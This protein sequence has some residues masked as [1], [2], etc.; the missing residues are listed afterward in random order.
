MK[1]SKFLIAAIAAAGM[2]GSASAQ[3]VI[4]I[5]GA[6]AFR[7]AA[8]QAILDSFD[9]GVEYG[10]Q[11]TNIGNAG[12]AIFNGTINAGADDVIVRTSW[13][14]SVAGIR[15]VVNQTNAVTYYAATPGT[16]GVL[17]TGGTNNLQSN[18]AV[19]TEDET[20]GNKICFADNSQDNTPF[21]AVTLLGGPAGVAVFVPV[22]NETP[23]I[24]QG[25]SI[26][27]AQLRT[28]MQ[29]GKAPLQFITGNASHSGKK[30]F[31]TGRQD[32]SGTRVIYL[33]EMGVGAST[34]I[35]QYRVEPL[36]STTTSASAV[37]IWPTGDT[38]N[39]SIIW[40]ADTAGN[41]G[42]SSGGALAPVLQRTSASVTEKNA[43]GGT[44]ASGVDAVLISVISSQEGQ[45]IQNGAGKVLAFNSVYIEP[46]ALPLGLSEA[47]KDQIRKGA[48]TLWSY[49]R[50]LYR[51][52]ISDQPTLD[53]IASMET[54][55]ALASNIGGNGVAISEM[56]VSRPAATDGGSLTVLGTLP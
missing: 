16:L 40:G 2:A 19:T 37:Q 7:Q 48:Y 29:A 50:F 39:R 49:E 13:S 12:R 34:A 25:D 11:S 46:E 30:I 20:T 6:T 9:A 41:G 44:V 14:G 8:H 4:N 15:A 31:W 1:T 32:T 38:T 21:D 35:N 47:D 22:V 36:D 23:H 51:D 17:T 52:D 10:Y 28:L 33:S 27:T 55:V 3:T 53:F 54:N 18:G 5:T 43:A 45:D 42:Y 24:T 56:L 26:S